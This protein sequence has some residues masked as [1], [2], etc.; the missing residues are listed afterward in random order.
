MRWVYGVLHEDRIVDTLRS[1]VGRRQGHLPPGSPEWWRLVAS[2]AVEHVT[3]DLA[4]Q[5]SH[6]PAR[7]ADDG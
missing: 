1:E 6:W 7:V 5:A 2:V 3:F 4:R